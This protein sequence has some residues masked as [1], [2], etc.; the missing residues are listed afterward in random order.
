MRKVVREEKNVLEMETNPT[1]RQIRHIAFLSCSSFFFFLP[2]SVTPQE[3]THLNSLASHLA[4]RIRDEENGE[5]TKSAISV[6]AP[7]EAEGKE[8]SDL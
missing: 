7:A 3:D 2:P 6:S 8:F 1:I 5:A 4:K